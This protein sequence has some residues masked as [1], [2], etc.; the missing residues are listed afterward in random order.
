MILPTPKLLNATLAEYN[1]SALLGALTASN[2][3]NTVSQLQNVT[4]FAPTN[5]AF[6]L[7]RTASQAITL[8][9][10]LKNHVVPAFVSLPKID[11]NYT[12]TSLYNSTLNVNVDGQNASVTSTAIS[13]PAKIVM[14]DVLTVNGIVHIIDAVLLPATLGQNRGTE[15]NKAVTSF[16]FEVK[17]TSLL[18]LG[19]FISLAL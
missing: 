5:S 8:D 16:G 9:S 3:L 17:V 11:G 15:G 18:I 4:I 13:T 12:L 19:T 10:I 7:L 1:L 2:L 6:E 14:S